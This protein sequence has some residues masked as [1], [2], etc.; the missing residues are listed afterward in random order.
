MVGISSGEHTKHK[1]FLTVCFADGFLKL[2]EKSQVQEKLNAFM[3]EKVDFDIMPEG[4]LSYKSSTK[5][6]NQGQKAI[7]TVTWTCQLKDGSEKIVKKVIES[8]FD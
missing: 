7:K 1:V 8:Q 2:G 6:T 3:K 4:T 5:V